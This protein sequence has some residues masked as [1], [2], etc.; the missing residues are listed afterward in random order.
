[1]KCFAWCLSLWFGALP[2][3]S[4]N[5]RIQENRFEGR[6]LVRHGYVHVLLHPFSQ[7]L[8]ARVG[9]AG[10]GYWGTLQEGEA[11]ATVPG[12]FIQVGEKQIALLLESGDVFVPAE[13]YCQALGL[14]ISRDAGGGL[15]VHPKVQPRSGARRS[16]PA[17]PADYFV[18]QYQSRY[19][20]W[21]PKHSANCG[22]ACMAMVALAYGLAPEGLL[23]GDR[24]GLILWC[25]QLMTRGNQ[26]QNRATKAREIERVAIQLGLT[27]HW[28]R[29]YRDIDQ[30]LAEGQLVVV[31][32]DTNRIGCPGGDH[33]LLCVGRLGSDYIINDPGGFFPTPGAHLSEGQMEQFF[34]EAIALAPKS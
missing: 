25:R 12:G 9:E 21:A 13:A 17:N 8:G 27:P 29:R 28:I 2:G 31:G 23:P 32:G 4:Q 24:Q 26:D 20:Q 11:P 7:A 5:I 6:Y 15:R 22:P 16:I 19:N 33:F 30:A 3:W 34:I 14:N 18:T 1:M 10:E